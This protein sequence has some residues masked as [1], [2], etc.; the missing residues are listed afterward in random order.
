MT[1]AARARMAAAIAVG[2]L[3]LW[4]T[5]Q[6]GWAFAHPVYVDVDELAAYDDH[7]EALGDDYDEALGD[8][9]DDEAV[10][11]DEAE[12]LGDSYDEQAVGRDDDEALDDESA[13]SRALEPAGADAPEAAPL[14]ASEWA[15]WFV[16]MLSFAM[17]FFALAWFGRTAR[18]TAALVAAACFG[19]ISLGSAVSFLAE[20]AGAPL[21]WLDT[22]T[23]PLIA[24]GTALGTWAASAPRRAP[25]ALVAGAIVLELL[26]PLLWADGIAPV[27]PVYAALFVLAFALRPI[28]TEASPA[29][30]APA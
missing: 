29:T 8:D 20:A 30:K 25:I 28:A 12:A 16:W 15:L 7:D 6:A 21:F 1:T 23:L 3:A 9:Y 2:L 5:A 4:T 22:I 14:P 18:R 19:A 13:P 17:V 11:R 10:G 24:V 27:P 26:S